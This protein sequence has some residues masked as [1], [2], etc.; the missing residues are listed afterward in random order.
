[1]LI[2]RHNY[3]EFF[4][5]YVDNEL[6]ADDQTAVENFAK[7]NPDL[8]KEFK[9]LQQ[10]ILTNNTILFTKKEILYKKEKGISLDN[11]EEYFLLFADNE[12][13]EQQL[14]EVENFV[15][16][17]PVLQNEFALL[18]Q[19]RL[20]PPLV[21]FAGK[22]TLYRH[23]KKERRIIP[24]FWMRM[25]AAAIMGVGISIFVLNFN[26]KS[27]PPVTVLTH[28]VRRIK[29]SPE[30]KDTL[31]AQKI[32]TEKPPASLTV[33][34]ERKN[35][36]KSTLKVTAGKNKAIQSF[37]KTIVIHKTKLNPK[38][39]TIIE[40]DSLLIAKTAIDKPENFP[41]KQIKTKR[42]DGKSTIDKSNSYSNNTFDKS[43][44]K[45][46]IIDDQPVLTSHAVYIE[47]DNNEEEKTLY[48]GAAEINKN[49]LKGLFKKATVF[50]DKK[51]RRNDD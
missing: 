43:L 21:T 37:E 1:V 39:I 45:Q 31:L 44:V 6:N 3:E 5:L 50:F 32:V 26:N 24:A 17:H 11:Y 12:L 34:K 19:T 42:F 14:A 10:T 22:E 33:E 8:A 48:I 9:M 28:S 13:T 29:T 36:V 25:S 18:Q 23:E 2:N 38:H 41:H 4:L 35:N 15:L 51:I 27:N 46:S 47:T 16:K 7:Q 30:K 40:T 20:E 49:K